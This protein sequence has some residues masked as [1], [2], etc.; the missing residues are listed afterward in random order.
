MAKCH[1]IWP[2]ASVHF[3][4]IECNWHTVQ[5]NSG[6]FLYIIDSHIRNKLL[7]QR[8]MVLMVAFS[9]GLKGINS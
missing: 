6:V 9:V 3:L 8:Q 7:P 5:S 4:K 1:Q 2:P